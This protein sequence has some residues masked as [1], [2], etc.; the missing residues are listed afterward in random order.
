MAISDEMKAEWDN[1][2]KQ[3]QQLGDS[4]EEMD[5]P[6]RDQ[7]GGAVRK[8]R[9]SVEKMRGMMEENM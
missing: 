5:N 9:E 3:I 1:L 8:L 4:V 7:L 2:T 6:V